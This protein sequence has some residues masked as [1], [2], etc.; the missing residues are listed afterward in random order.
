[1]S[2]ERTGNSKR[3]RRQQ[4]AQ[5]I[6]GGATEPPAN[7]RTQCCAL[8]LDHFDC[9]VRDDAPK[10]LRVFADIEEKRNGGQN[11]SGLKAS[12]GSELSMHADIKTNTTVSRIAGIAVARAVVLSRSLS[13]TFP[14]SRVEDPSS[15][16]RSIMTPRTAVKRMNSSPSVSTAR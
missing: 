11:H 14:A 8:C 2:Q 13:S 1:M 9:S 15:R 6:R 4:D 5:T 7:A 10:R 12:S 3:D 16:R